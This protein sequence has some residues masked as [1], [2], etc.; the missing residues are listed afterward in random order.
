MSRLWRMRLVNIVGK[1]VQS[2]LAQL[3]DGIM[4]IPLMIGQCCQYD[5]IYLICLT[6]W[7][8]NIFRGYTFFDGY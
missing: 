7:R 1:K 8:V 2:L 6:F 5:A 4:S 3:S